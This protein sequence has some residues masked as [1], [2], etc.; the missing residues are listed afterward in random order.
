MLQKQKLT[1]LMI[2]IILLI[3][4][5]FRCT[6]LPSKEEKK[7]LEPMKL[8]YWRVWDSPAN[9]SGIISSYKSVHPNISIEIQT[10]RYEEYEKMIMNS[11]AELNPPD[12]ISLHY[13]W[14][15]KYA[16]KKFIVPIPNKIS[17]A[18]QYKKTSMGIKEEMVTEM[19]NTPIPTLT[20][21]KNDYLDTVSK[22]VVINNKIYGLPL[23]VDTMV[24]YYNRDLLD[25]AHIPIPP[26][27]WV[28]FQDAVKKITALNEKGGIEISGAA[29][30]TANN[31]R[32]ST[33][34]LMLLMM[35]NGGVIMG[36]GGAKFTSNKEGNNAGYI[37]LQF[38][39]DFSNPQKEVYSWN[40]D[41]PDSLRAFS[42]KKVAFYFGYSYDL[43]Y[44]QAYSRNSINLGITKMPQIQE[45]AGE[46]NMAN[47]WVEAV[48]SRSKHINEAWD[49]ILFATTKKDQVTK[50][51]KSAQKPTALR[52][53][54]E[55]QLQDEKTNVFAS[56]LLTSKTWYHGMDINKAEEVIKDMINNVVSG[57]DTAEN[58][59]MASDRLDETINPQ[60]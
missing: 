49:F 14:L 24:L 6:L 1:I 31:I 39:T 44:I 15:P 50:Y 29:L 38:Y 34:I 53:L 21:L 51:L 18:Y 56:Q 42:D 35:Q 59:N 3:T 46:V 52:S 33:D 41:M 47:Y 45:G 55:S 12:I 16:K 23:S 2:I 43:P 19:K 10:L 8:R 25:K 7:G 9:F 48:S 32:R 36:S 40:N 60:E 4:T 5:G 26:T 28:E 20:Q 37:A 27:N 13:A 30:G 54:V 11:Y 22:D 58:M 17:M 57:Q